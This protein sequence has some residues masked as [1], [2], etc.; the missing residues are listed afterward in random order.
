MAQSETQ[1]ASTI[2]RRMQQIVQ[3]SELRLSSVLFYDAAAPEVRPGI[4]EGAEDAIQLSGLVCDVGEHKLHRID[5]DR[6]GISKIGPAI[7]EPTKRFPVESLPVQICPP[8]W[9]FPRAAG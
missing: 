1:S 6:V 2:I 9:R 4:A 7:D 8:W 5:I 3:F